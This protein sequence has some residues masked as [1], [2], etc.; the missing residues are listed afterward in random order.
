MFQR[1][2]NHKFWKTAD[3]IL[4]ETS[5][6]GQGGAGLLTVLT[7]PLPEGEGEAVEMA[8]RLRRMLDTIYPGLDELYVGVERSDAPM[9]YSGSLRPGE[10]AHLSI[11]D[12]GAHWITVGEASSGE[13]QGYLEGALRSADSGVARYV[14]HK[15]MQKKVR[16]KA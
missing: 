4:V 7:G 2:N 12:G 6:T 16:K 10:A 11:H 13:L 3:C 1:L 5:G 8:A 14:M 9:S 15:R